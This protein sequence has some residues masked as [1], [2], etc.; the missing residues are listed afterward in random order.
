M[1]IL[2]DKNEHGKRDDA[3]KKKKRRTEERLTSR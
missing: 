3:V 1:K 2:I